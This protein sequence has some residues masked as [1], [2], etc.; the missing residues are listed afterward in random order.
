MF[1][2]RQVSE[3]RDDIHLRCSICNSES[4]LRGLSWSG[5]VSEQGRKPQGR[6]EDSDPWVNLKVRMKR[7]QRTVIHDAM[8][9][10][11]SESGVSS[12]SAATSLEWIAADFIAGRKH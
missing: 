1:E 10:V 2:L 11:R 12:Q 4:M 8:G 6:G 5:V 7:S 3:S 9:L